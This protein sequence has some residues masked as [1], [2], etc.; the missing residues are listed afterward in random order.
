MLSIVSFIEILSSAVY[1]IILLL[2]SFFRENEAG[3]SKRKIACTRE[4]TSG[5]PTCSHYSLRKK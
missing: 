5:P 4:K 2:F 3:V 1:L